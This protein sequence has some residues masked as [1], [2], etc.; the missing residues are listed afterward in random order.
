MDLPDLYHGSAQHSSDDAFGFEFKIDF[1]S[2]GLYDVQQLEPTRHSPWLQAGQKIRV[3]Q[4][5]AKTNRKRLKAWEN[6]GFEP[7]AGPDGEEREEVEDKADDEVQVY[8]QIFVGP[9]QAGQSKNPRCSQPRTFAEPDIL[10]LQPF[11]RSTA[12]GLDFT[13]SPPLVSHTF[14]LTWPFSMI[15][16]TLACG[17]S[18]KSLRQKS[19]NTLPKTWERPV[20]SRLPL[21]VPAQS[22]A[23]HQHL[24]TSRTAAPSRLD[25]FPRSIPH[26]SNPKRRPPPHRSRFARIGNNTSFP[27]GKM[28]SATSAV[29]RFSSSS[30]NRWAG[31][32]DR[33]PKRLGRKRQ[34]NVLAD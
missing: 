7:G 18:R 20:C 11:G 16:N 31:M 33:W 17:R 26:I 25:V 5:L 8:Y 19:S 2:K 27:S 22:I 3:L 1:A 4:G 29:K 15:F 13:T 32:V 34:S 6:G 12:I 10:V 23:G 9:D 28:T 30:R 14:S 24:L 21:P